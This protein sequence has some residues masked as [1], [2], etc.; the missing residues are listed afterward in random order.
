MWQDI[1]IASTAFILGLVLI[2]QIV[3]SF[4][5]KH[6]NLWTSGLTATGLASIG[7]V[8]MTLGLFLGS[9][10]YLFNSVLWYVIF[11]LGFRR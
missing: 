8:M 9:T 6:V 4:K 1:F 3:S 2:P 10:A 11:F 7:V 5:G